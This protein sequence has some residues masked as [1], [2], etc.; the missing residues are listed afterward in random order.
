[1]SIQF[2]KFKTFTLRQ[3]IIFYITKKS[4]LHHLFEPIAGKMEECQKENLEEVSFRTKEEKEADWIGER[5]RR[6]RRG[7]HTF[8]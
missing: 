1:M 8:R 7:K 3:I 6:G 4:I 2:F 5:D